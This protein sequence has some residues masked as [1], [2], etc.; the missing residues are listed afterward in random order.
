M[1]YVLILFLSLFISLPAH[2]N[3]L[4]KVSLQLQWLHQFQF[5][6]YYVA[7]EKGLYKD[8]G[9]NV[10]IKEFKPSIDTVKEVLSGNSTYGIGLSS[11]IQRYSKNDP[12]VLISAIF[13]SSPLVLIALKSSHINKIED[14]EGKRVML[15][16]DMTKAVALHAMIKSESKLDDNIHYIKHSLD[17]DDLIKGKVDLYSAYISNEPYILEKRNI[18]FRVFSPKDEGFDFYSDI[19]FTSAKEVE[20]NPLRVK[21]FKEASLKGWQYAFDNIDETVDLIY[22]KYNPKH[23]TKDALLY[24]AKRLKKL[25]YANNAKLGEIDKKTTQRILDIYRFLD[26]IKENIDINELIFDNQKIYF[27]K[28]EQT[29]LRKKGLIKICATTNYLPYSAI[30]NSK[31]NGIGSGIIGL[32]ENIINTPFELAQSKIWSEPITALAQKKCDILPVA[33]KTP[34]LERYFHF[35]SPYYLE[36][37]VIITKTTTNYILDIASLMDKEFS[38]VKDSSYISYLKSK[39]PKIKLNIVKSIQ[40]GLEGVQSGKYYGHID[41]MTNSA[42]YLQKLSKID[43]KIS[44]QFKDRVKIAFAVRN[45]DEQLFKIFEKV[46]QN[47]HTTDVQN[48]LNKW[49]SLNFT[50]KIEFRYIWEVLLISFVL[51]ATLYYRQRFL[52]KKNQELEILQ[53]EL[54]ELNKSLESR[55]AK[56]VSEIQKK[57]TYL[58][59][60]SKLAQMGEMMSMIAHQWKQPLGSISATQISIIMAL[61]LEEYN[62]DDKLQQ[63]EFLKFLNEKLQKI[64]LYTKSL[65]EI[66]SDFSDFYKPS[67]D[68]DYISVDE[69]ILKASRLIETTLEENMVDIFLNLNSK[70]KIRLYQNEFMQVILNIVNNAKEQLLQND[71]KHKNIYINTHELPKTVIIEINDNAGG[72]DDNIMSRIFEPYFSTKI[73]RNGTGLGLHMSKNIIEQHH[74]GM[75][76]A[77]NY[78]N[79]AMFT[80]ELNKNGEIVEI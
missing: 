54:I 33:Q 60:Q 79:G 77:K 43:L 6:G 11:L 35:T 21:N 48:I 25:A 16:N 17:I 68:A 78:K 41:I 62:F 2:D 7:K 12:L 36:P 29:Y 57:D 30:E 61:E 76:Y 45:D 67:K 72:I 70:T 50:Q 38:V 5:A 3:G 46:S 34:V 39:Y 18:P 58:L 20:Q 66:I 74:H 42:Y 49:V 22:K 1:R 24:E 19:L 40:D 9:L 26:L 37:L 23:K 13:Q 53:N 47:I 69:V 27:T 80:I 28:D 73:E 52:N 32:A 56:S 75:I 8:V 55:V 4:Q 59:Q 14:F 44:G 65:S 10:E 15:T 71:T 63:K 51:L 64:E 31:L